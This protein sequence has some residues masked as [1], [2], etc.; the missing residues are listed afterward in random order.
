M[1]TDHF[2]DDLW[3]QSDPVEPSPLRQV[4]DVRPDVDPISPDLSVLAQQLV[5][6]VRT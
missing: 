3:A 4:S 5:A 2:A 6:E 1:A